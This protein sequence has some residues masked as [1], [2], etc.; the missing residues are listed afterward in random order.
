MSELVVNNKAF[1]Y[2]DPGTEPGWG[3]EATDWAKEVTAVLDSISGVGTIIETITTIENNISVPTSIPALVFNSN[4]TQ[5]IKLFYKIKRD[6]DSVPEVSEQGVLELFY[7][8]G[9]WLVSRE[10]SVGSPTGVFFDIDN[11]GQIKY[12]SSNLAGANYVG[13]IRFKTISV[14]K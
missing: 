7:T 9:T 4:L 12:T 11:T 10:I 8:N 1:N 6:T 14:L 2:P 5:A 3:A 13:S